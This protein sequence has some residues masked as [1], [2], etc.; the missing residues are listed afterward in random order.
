[1]MVG[2]AGCA[3]GSAAPSG[4]ADQHRHGDHEGRHGDHHGHHV[5]RHDFSDVARWSSVF[6]NPE[7]DAWQKP[8]EVIAVASVAPGMVVADIGA[9]TG[10]F[11]PHLSRA[12]G[13]SGKVLAIDV[14]PAFIEHMNARF[15]DASLA[16]IDA[17]LG[18][19]DDPGLATRGVERILIV[20][21]WHHVDDRV[22]YAQQ[23]VGALVPGGRLAIVD[24]TAESPH[25]PPVR[26]RLSPEAV[27]AEL[28][29]AGFTATIADETLP[30]QYIVIGES[31]R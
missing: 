21:T 27:V 20:N 26:F 6:D 1:M 7:R 2:L 19:P 24:F 13:E 12:V 11:E 9:G 22:S 10:Y 29:A 18:R 5:M 28:E 3:S 23:L 8:A 4:E 15:R 16:N 14:E 31:P 17:R 25:G 30:H